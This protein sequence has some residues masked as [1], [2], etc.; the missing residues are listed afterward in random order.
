MESIEQSFSI[1]LPL[2]E[3]EGESKSKLK[4]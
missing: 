2:E 1:S 3:V 4:S